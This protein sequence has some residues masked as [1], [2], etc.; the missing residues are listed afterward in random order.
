MP[1]IQLLSLLFLVLSVFAEFNTYQDV[2][3]SITD[4]LMDLDKAVSSINPDIESIDPVIPASE[5]VVK[6]FNA[7]TKNI[8][9]TPALTLHEL[10]LFLVTGKT[11]VDAANFTMMRLEYKK[12]LVDDSKKS[13]V[14]IDAVRKVGDAA[15]A[16]I[17]VVLTKIPEEAKMLV[18]DQCN[19]VIGSF[20]IGVRLFVP[21]TVIARRRIGTLRTW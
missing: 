5:A 11:L 21:T 6:T 3:S 8:S 10:Q 14:I 20:E 9:D 17:T 18:E 16:F 12:S 15:K 1:L 19:D 4:S 2:Y 13:N 7:G